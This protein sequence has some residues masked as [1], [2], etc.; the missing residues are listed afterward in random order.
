MVSD[1]VAK[2]ISDTSYLIPILAVAQTKSSVVVD[3][4]R[5]VLV[6]DDVRDLGN[7]GSLVRTARGFGVKDIWITTSDFDPM[8][9]KTIDASRGLV[10]STRFHRLASAEETAFSLKTAGYEIV[11]TSPHAKELQ[12]QVRLSG[13]P[14]ALVVGNETNGV[15]PPLFAAADKVVQIPMRSIESLNVVVATGI[16]IY[17]LGYRLVLMKMTDSIRETFG[18]EF[19]STHELIHQLLNQ[20][21]LEVGHV[22]ADEVI[23]LM[24]LACDRTS[25]I[26][27]VE[28]D[29]QKIGTTLDEFLL[30][31]AENRYIMIN[32]KGQDRR[33]EISAE[34][35][36]LLAQLWPIIE[37]THDLSLA[38]L[39]DDDLDRLRTSLKIIQK[40]CCNALGIK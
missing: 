30:Q 40:N 21:L 18:R 26:R 14:V 27:E 12:S 38:G 25:A 32:G 3:A 6:L 17:E 9:R 10:F 33:I 7:I 24:R 15:S 37:S 16:S 1:G 11:V 29:T 34:G 35:E 19:G 23:F 28:T 39:S 36:I 13:R 20:R 8:S 2:K 31:L 5:L 22:G 4:G